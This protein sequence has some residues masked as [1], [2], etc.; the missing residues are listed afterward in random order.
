MSE[1]VDQDAVET[2]NIG[3]FETGCVEG[4]GF[5]VFNIAPDQYHRT[6]ALQR[7]GAINIT[8]T[9]EKVVHG[10]MT[11]DSDRYA[12]LVVM[13]WLFQPKGWRRISEATI[14]LLFTRNSGGGDVEVE[15]VSFHDTYSLM[16]ATQEESVTKGGE[17]TVGV[18]QFASL[19]ATGKWEKTVTRT[20]SHAIT[21][22]GGKHLVNN[23]PPNRIATWTLSEDPS[24]RAGIPASLKVAVLVSRED[25]E[26]F[27]CHLSFTCKTDWATK[28]QNLFQKIPKD[29]PIIF[30]PNPQHKGTRP[31]RNVVYGDE[32]L[33]KVDLNNLCDVTFRTV[34]N[35]GEKMWT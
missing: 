32:E 29:D 8:C 10:I 17:G 35:D 14:E 28:A 22:T 3:M 27:S 1:E 11:N 5:H 4:S 13:R 34:I 7:T 6:E 31:S 26:P 24:Q 16:Q 20:T 15:K 2:V 19:S 12:T 21:L 25:R 9:L 33:D 30:Q 23:R 18:D